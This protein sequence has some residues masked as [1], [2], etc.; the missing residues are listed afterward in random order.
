M[1]GQEDLLTRL[2]KLTE[3]MEK[4][5]PEETKKAVDDLKISID[6]QFN[7]KNTGIW[8][9]ISPIERKLNGLWGAAA[10]AGIGAAIF[11]IKEKLK[12]N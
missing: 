8:S 11:M 10:A 1:R 9:R 7:D 3:T 2:D 12:G 5:H 4:S 6:K